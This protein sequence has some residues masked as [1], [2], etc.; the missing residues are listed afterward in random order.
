M[1]TATNTQKIAGLYSAFFNRAPDSNGLATWEARINTEQSTL[2]DIAAGFAAHP[3][4]TTTYGDMTDQ[5]FVEAIYT[6]VLGSA[7]DSKGISYWL[8]YLTDP[9]TPHTRAD[10]VAQFVSDS[11]EYD[12]DA[13][14]AAGAIDQ[15][16]YD[17]ALTRQAFIT[18]K[19]DVGIYFAQTLGQHTNVADNN[20]P[21]QDPAYLA[22]IDIL[23]NV[24]DSADSVTAA[25]AT[26]DDAVA[27]ADP[28][29]AI[30]GETVVPGETY[31]LT[32]ADSAVD[33]GATASF[34]LTTENVA[35]GT[36]VAY[37]LSG[38]DAADVDGE[39]TGSATVDANGEA[40]IEV[41]LTEDATTEGAETLTVTL[42][43]KDVSAAVT[44]NDTSL[45]P[46]FSLTASADSVDE[47]ES[48]TVSIAN[49]EPSTEYVLKVDDGSAEFVP[50]TTDADGAA[51][52]TINA[53]S[54]L[55]ADSDV[56]V[57]VV[58][59]A[60]SVTFTQV[61]VNDA[62]ALT[63]DAAAQG[64]GEE[65]A[66]FTVN[67][68]DLLTGYT[69]EENDA[70]SVSNVAADN[71][72]T[73]T[74]N[75]DGTYTITPAADFNGVVT[76]SYDVT[77]GTET[78]AASWALDFAAVN[79]APVAED[80]TAAAAE[81]DAA[82]TGQLVASDI[83]GDDLTFALD[84]AV[85]GLTVNADGSWTF[86]PSLNTA[87]Q[88]LTYTDA[89][90]EI[91]ANYTVTDAAGA[92]DSKALTITVTPTP[93]TFELVS[94]TQFVEEGSEIE[95]TIVA[96][97]A[98]QS[99]FTG[100][101]QILPGDGSTG[102]TSTADFGSGS[103]NPQTV[104]IAVGETVSTVATI[105]PTND[106]A[107]ELPEGYT[108]S[109]TVEG[110]EIADLAGEVRDPSSV[111]GLGQTFTLTTG[112]DT[113]P[114]LNGSAGTTGTDGDDTIV[115]LVDSKTATNSTLNALDQ[116]NAGLGEDT[117]TLNH[118]GTG[119]TNDS[120]D[121]IPA[122]VT[123]QNVET[124]NIRSSANVG[125]LTDSDVAGDDAA[126]V[127]NLSNIAGLNTVN[128]TLANEVNI[129]GA[130][131]TDMNVSGAS[132][133]IAVA[134][135]QNV[136]VTDATVDTTITVGNNAAGGDAAG[137]IT[138]T[139][140]NNAQSAANLSNI[141]VEG[142]TDVTVTTTA[143]NS[144]TEAASGNITVGGANG[145]PTGAVVVN[146]TLSSDGAAF[147][148]GTT[149]T[150]GGTTVDV[151]VT[152]T[153]TADAV[154]DAGVLAVGA[155]NVNAG[156]A[157]T[158]VNVTQNVTNTTFSVAAAGATTESAVVTF[159]ALAA[160]EAVTISVGAADA[161][162]LTF[163]A[164]RALTGAEV[165][166]AFAALTAADTQAEGGVVANGVFTGT[167]DA[168]Y[169][170][171]AATG[172]NVTFTAT[173]AGVSGDITVTTAAADAAN[174]N[175]AT[176][177]G[178][179]PTT[180]AAGPST[181]TAAAGAVTVTE[182][183]TASVTN[184][185]LDGYG[186]GSD[187]VA[188]DALT[189]LNLANS[190]QGLTVDAAVAALT[191]NLDAI[192]GAAAI[193]LDDAGDAANATLTALTV[194]AT[195]GNSAVDLTA[196]AA[197]AVTINATSNLDLTGSSFNAV[198]TVTVTGAGAVTLDE[199]GGYAAA[200]AINASANTGGVDA[201]SQVLAAGTV[202]TGGTGADTVQLGASTANSTMGDGNDTVT[203]TG[204][205]LGGGS[206]DAG[207]GTADTLVMTAANAETAANTLTFENTISNFERLSVGQVA[208]TAD[209]T[210]NLANMDDIS[211][212][213]T[214]GTLDTQEVTSVA[215]T[216]TAAGAVTGGTVS[217]VVGGTTYSATGASAN[218]ALS[219]LATAV[220]AD[221]RV[222]TATV[223]NTDNAPLVITSATGYAL[224]VG[225][226]VSTLA[227]AGAVTAGT[228][229]I[230]SSE[231][232]FT[233]MANDGTVQL[234]AAGLGATVTMTDATGAADSLNVVTAEL[235]ATNVGTVAVAGVETINV[236]TTDAFTDAN[237]DGADDVASAVTLNVHAAAMTTLNVSGAGD[238]T[239]DTLSTVL[240]AV[241]ASLA[242]GI[243]TYTADGA[244]A[245]TTVTGG[246]AADVLTAA[247][248]SDVLIGG[249]G[250]DTLTGA[251]LTQL[252]GG[253]GNDTFVLN[254]PTNVN[255]YSTI[256]DLSA[257]D[258][259][260]LNDADA[261]V[262]DND[263]G[264]V[265]FTSAAIQLAN[266]AV[267]QDY[268]NA[269][270]NINDGNNAVTWFQFGENTYVV[271]DANNADVDFNNGTDSIIQIT[272]LVDLSTASYNQ[273][274]GTLEIA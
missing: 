40:T 115:A 50:V 106:A 254:I 204:A 232:F 56:T 96:S 131:T 4:F 235:A 14:W 223:A 58:G 259:I 145:S 79:D 84:A 80:A 136:T 187:I 98:V 27:S 269:A 146:S 238:L 253:E 114:G 211:Y 210:I 244:A 141:V 201:D 36:E 205:A 171:G 258:V 52:L 22:S 116:I 7:G 181:N 109:A 68:S 174:F 176:T 69:D 261:V 64:A 29:G 224:Q 138:V 62:P 252:T 33:E 158:S 23:S 39:L 242:T 63:G 51:T 128:V 140:T 66:A 122:G 17:A 182:N 8:N 102:Q 76:V 196:D 9:V 215:G 41:V 212:V 125:D 60:D 155:I 119:N 77:D 157:T 272:G 105:T 19:A 193:D 97:E 55:A 265:T 222:A 219:A 161:G 199:D 83:D 110:Y 268:A 45:T 75:E 130:A 197:T 198:E 32:A 74:D 46:A 163:T 38:V 71:G 178:A 220:A 274:N 57:S 245:G 18:N 262:G 135:G 85:E 91:V 82:I 43:G 73:V 72:A 231:L 87:A 152:A 88:A 214:A 172:A 54:N 94:N 108:A 221:A 270:V 70:L 15:A 189:T 239:L 30:L 1:P 240:T 255:S 156:N 170:S 31:T 184:I 177:Q 35:E 236:T 169:T 248:N 175:V 49:G 25:K 229:T 217:I 48:L 228:A 133:A 104:T 2:S 233:N 263:L 249:A 256:T 120:L 264:A 11:L 246:S 225:Q 188:A 99:E 132:G 139:D 251:S 53:S 247:G 168:G 179:A 89:D 200:T 162:D 267:F 185:T 21:E 13:A 226:L 159:G 237:N 227:G 160:G 234:G 112:I 209:N 117:L 90:L 271:R 107:A 95:Y 92:T 26:I 16:T 103:F 129:Q 118:V 134:G 101:I 191:V 10:M 127:L 12:A 260:D 206:V 173:A 28:V 213:I 266:T 111:G 190:A 5:Q 143:A 208:T 194:N 65:D 59:R 142:G 34:T 183:A 100:T 180:A 148:G 3:L 250:N 6:N 164:G 67:A 154:A 167:L 93:L 218:A 241:D 37:T 78:V 202:F 230:T 123:I 86:D 186:A 42:D 61:A 144:A 273:T 195:G 124:I 153:N 147:A 81:A 243:L 149:T 151:N 216:Y 257:G 137:T 207:A 121:A 44:V 20:N 165:A 24:T 203:L 192:T 166:A 126:A 150:N 47:G 113:I